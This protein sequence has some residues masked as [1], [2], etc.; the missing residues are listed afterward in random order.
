MINRIK[1]ART[2]NKYYDSFLNQN[3]KQNIILDLKSNNQPPG[4]TKTG[5]LEFKI[6][7]LIQSFNYNSRM[8]K[9]SRSILQLTNFKISPKEVNLI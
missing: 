5:N 3:S 9:L 7:S 1:L 4:S 2:A 8:D 6:K